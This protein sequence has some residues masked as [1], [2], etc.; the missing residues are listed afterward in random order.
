M[1]F[2]TVLLPGLRREEKMRIYPKTRE[3][4]IC[5][6]CF[7]SLYRQD[8]GSPYMPRL[9]GERMERKWFVRDYKSLYRGR[10]ANEQIRTP[11]GPDPFKS[12]K[13]LTLCAKI[14]FTPVFNIEGICSGS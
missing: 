14:L 4:G 1:H 7:Y 12:N 3:A 8:I 6:I 11:V 13:K 2:K 10:G 5:Y 9:V